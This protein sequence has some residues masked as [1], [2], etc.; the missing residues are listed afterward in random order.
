MLAATKR[1]MAMALR[2]AGI[3]EGNG[4]IDKSDGVGKE[5]GGQA[6]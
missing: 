3:E 1:A 2:V 5:G 4:D 6:L